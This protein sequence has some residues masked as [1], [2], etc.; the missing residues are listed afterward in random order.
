VLIK[1]SYLV[2]LPF[3]STFLFLDVLRISEDVC[4]FSIVKIYVVFQDQFRCVNAFHRC[5]TIGAEVE[6]VPS[7]RSMPSRMRHPSPSCHHHH[8]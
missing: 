4:S 7:K 6:G 5:P 3:T 1:V 2:G 8:P